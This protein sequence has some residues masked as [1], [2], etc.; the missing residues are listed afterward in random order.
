MI[1]INFPIRM[2]VKNDVSHTIH[3]LLVKRGGRKV[4][5]KHS[6]KSN[7]GG[8]FGFMLIKKFPQSFHSGN[9]AKY[10][11]WT[12][13]SMKTSKNHTLLMTTRFSMEGIKVA[14][15]LIVYA[16]HTL[17]W[18]CISR[19]VPGWEIFKW[20]L[21][22]CVTFQSTMNSLTKIIETIETGRDGRE[23]R[24]LGC[25]NFLWSLLCGS[26]GVR[27]PTGAL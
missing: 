8:H 15:G 11:Q 27:L 13:K 7:R 2:C 9:Q 22:V 14:N 1:Q 4:V 25:L 26:S 21:S 23:L 18:I 3:G 16:S 5:V 20:A 10:L 17:I 6:I 19:W 12:H 24:G